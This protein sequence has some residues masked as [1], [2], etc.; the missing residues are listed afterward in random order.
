LEGFDRRH[1]VGPNPAKNNSV[2]GKK[3]LDRQVH[4]SLS[5]KSADEESTEGGV[6]EHE[7]DEAEALGAF[8]ATSL[9]GADGRSAK[10][11]AS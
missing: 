3:K 2:S 4:D 1:S 8:V 9:A 7:K 6:E 5:D 10:R 11:S